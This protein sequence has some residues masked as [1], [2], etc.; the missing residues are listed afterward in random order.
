MRRAGLH[1]DVKRIFPGLFEFMGRNPYEWDVLRLR[2]PLFPNFS[3]IASLT[4][5]SHEK[6]SINFKTLSG[7]SWQIRLEAQGSRDYSRRFS[8][9]TQNTQRLPPSGQ[10]SLRKRAKTREKRKGQTAVPQRGAR[11]M[12]PEEK[13]EHWMTVRRQ[14]IN[15]APFLHPLAFL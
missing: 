4:A 8:P 3:V 15:E 13:M 12:T 9:R 5:L 11:R 7:T 1:W 2:C 10:S 6:H 14:I